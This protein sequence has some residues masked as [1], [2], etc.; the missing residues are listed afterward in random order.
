[1]A[2]VNAF[3]VA[4]INRFTIVAKALLAEIIAVLFSLFFEFLCFGFPDPSVDGGL[5]NPLSGGCEKVVHAS[6]IVDNL[7]TPIV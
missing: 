5:A 7:K 6:L 4:A 3:V 2:P 1:L